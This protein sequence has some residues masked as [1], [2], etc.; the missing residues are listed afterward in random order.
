MFKRQ[1]GKEQLI[2]CIMPKYIS[3]GKFFVKDNFS[4]DYSFDLSI[5]YVN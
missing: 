5:C 3:Q 4:D 1:S 2:L